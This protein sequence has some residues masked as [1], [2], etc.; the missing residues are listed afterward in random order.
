MNVVRPVCVFICGAVSL[1]VC[2]WCVWQFLSV[3]CH[4]Q[5]WWGL[6][7]NAGTLGS[8]VCHSL[9][10]FQLHLAE[11]FSTYIGAGVVACSSWIAAQ[12]LTTLPKND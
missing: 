2:H 7:T 1:S 5:T 9:N 8:P 3:S 4:S 6:L 12:H 11:Y 10:R